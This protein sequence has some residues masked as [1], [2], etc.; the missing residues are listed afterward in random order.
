M[1]NK[2]TKRRLSDFLA[3]EWIMM[4]IIA[5][6]AMIVWE[7]VYTMA[8][9][10]LSVGQQFKFYFDETVYGNSSAVV[11]LL[12][13]D[14]TLSYDILEL[15][16]ESLSSDFNV[17][18]TRLSIQEGDILITDCKYPTEGAEK[19]EEV[20]DKKIRLRTMVDSYHGYSYEEMLLD[21]KT[22]LRKYM[23]STYENSD[24]VFNYV[25]DGIFDAEKIEKSFRSRMKKD[26]RFRK[27][28]D[29]KIGIGL[30]TQRIERLYKEVV[31]FSK[32]LEDD[33]ENLFYR[34]T[35]YSQSR[36][37]QEKDID[38]QAWADYMQKEINRLTDKGI[39]GTV[40]KET[41]ETEFIY[42]INLGAM[43]TVEGKTNPSDLCTMRDSE[44]AE[45]V[46]IMVFDFRSYHPHLQFETISFINTIVRNCST[47][48]DA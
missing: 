37:A 13:K 35:K 28:S 48:L 44:S 38:K 26:N 15:N 34:Y 33:T 11:R 17:L 31:D 42:A 27:E 4:I 12:D 2:I 3:Y 20:E 46:C 8:G 10:R 25:Q 9:V 40:N 24:A 14:Q 1:D 22:Y 30:E 32:L 47:L 36:D 5:V 6:V 29:K 23:L 41:N 19:P 7:L 39:A 16:A 45:N 18:S 43:P 21:A